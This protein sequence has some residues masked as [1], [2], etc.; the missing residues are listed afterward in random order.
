MSYR[1]TTAIALI[2][3]GAAPVF[4]DVTPA[5][6]WDQLQASINTDPTVS[7]TIGSIDETPERIIVSNMAIQSDQDDVSFSA[8]TPSLTL[9]DRGDGTVEMQYAETSPIL[10]SSTQ[11]GDEFELAFDVIQTNV[12]YIVSGDPE[13][14]NFSL[15]GDALELQLTDIGGM[16]ESMLVTGNMVLS[17]LAGNSIYTG[18]DDL[19]YS[20][21]FTAGSFTTD[22]S[23]QDRA[24]GTGG[25]IKS[26]IDGMRID[27]QVA[28]P[29][30]ISDDDL[31][32]KAGMVKLDSTIGA[33]S[34][35]VNFDVG[36][37][38]FSFDLTMEG[39]ATDLALSPD[40]LFYDSSLTGANIRA[41]LPDVLP[42]PIEASL[43]KFATV[44]KGPVNADT[45][46]D[47]Q[48]GLTIAD[49]SVSDGIWNLFDPGQLLQRDPATLDVQLS[50][51]G[52][53]GFD[54]TVLEEEIASSGNDEIPGKIESAQIDR[55]FVNA[56]GA[57][58]NGTGSFT[59]DNTDFMTFPGSPRPE[60][61]AKLEV[62]G[63]NALLDTLIQM[64][65]VAQEEAMGMRM[66]MAMFTNP[67]P[68]EDS[69]STELE[70]N[71]QGHVIVNGQRLR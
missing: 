55:L 64:G 71:A 33:T 62:T 43:G 25:T 50:G 70:V 51:V 12:R 7:L 68:T 11:P 60:G 22:I 61:S 42:F 13:L 27:T 63:L 40:G 36:D 16:P 59:F 6:V 67:G 44:L 45:T 30:N 57:T 47:I 18:G 14:M 2:F 56:A 24:D 8:L 54:L 52:E 53:I 10:I 21:D 20:G 46:G 35:N 69:M 23:M 26:T 65:F 48:L 28:I 29:A 58:A 39:S 15:S 32:V 38:P 9:Q 17:D 4:A 19:A 5:D 1:T 41:M 3:S 34:V 66:G 49:L 37:G 31:F